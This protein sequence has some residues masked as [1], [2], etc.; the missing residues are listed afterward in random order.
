MHKIN[1]FS[2]AIAAAALLT[3]SLAG[4]SSAT[5]DANQTPLPELT[6]VTHDSAVFTEE[7]LAEFKAETGITVTQLK[8]GDAGEMTNKLVLTADTPIGDAFFGIDNTFA[9]VAA[10]NKIIDGELTAVDYGDVC[11]NYDKKWFAD[12]GK[13]APTSIA[14]LTKPA[15]KNLTVVTNPT[16]SSPGL[17]FLAA[18]VAAFGEAGWQ[19]YWSALKANGVKVAAGW[20][21]AY[22][23]DF[24]GSSGAGAYP[25][26]LSYSSSPAFEVREDGQ[27]QTASIMDGCFRQ[28]EYAGVLKNAKNPA[29]AKLFVEFLTS[30]SFQVSLPDSMYVY[31]AVAG[32][33]LPEAWSKWAPLSTNPVGA[34][35]DINANREA[36]LQKWSAIFSGN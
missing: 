20:E 5:T 16:S 2:K 12:Q 29:G 26:V 4:C 21:D 14:D 18:T 11:F 6:V 32:T 34:D 17:A 19:D 33:P 24:S 23:T 25:I 1:H 35:L 3:I 36:W 22:F 9:G 7:L 13:S 27:S 10:D 15:Y 31:P 28:T 8:A 30:E